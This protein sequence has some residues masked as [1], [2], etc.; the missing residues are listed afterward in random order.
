V[1]ERRRPEIGISFRTG[2][3][4]QPEI[5]GAAGAVDEQGVFRKVPKSGTPGRGRTWEICERE[6]KIEE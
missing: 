5:T 6:D 4:Y 2:F 3:T 1:Q